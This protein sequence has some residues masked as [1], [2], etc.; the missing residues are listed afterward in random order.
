MAH[1]TSVIPNNIPN[2]E[3]FI[4]TQVNTFVSVCGQY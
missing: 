3:K 1:W 2:K 4:Q